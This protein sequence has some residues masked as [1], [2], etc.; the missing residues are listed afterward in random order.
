[1]GVCIIKANGAIIA[2]S[3]I[4]SV[5]VYKFEAYKITESDTRKYIVGHG[6]NEKPFGT[7][8]AIEPTEVAT[9]S[10]RSILDSLLILASRALLALPKDSD[11]LILSWCKMH[12]LPFCSIEASQRV[13]Y[14][15]CPLTQFR[16]FLFLLRDTFWKVESMY[17]NF[18]A[19]HDV[20]AF[21]KNPYM[22]Q[23]K[24]FTKGKK[25]RI[26]SF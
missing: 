15:A 10:D 16:D 25:E 9:I 19:E 11:N 7:N 3:D 4:V 26:F 12:G 18:C 20:D 2:L 13:G 8:R 24:H 23:S 22:K 5:N 6:R 14:I 21:G 17:E 1:M